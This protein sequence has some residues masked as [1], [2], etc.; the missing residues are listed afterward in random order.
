MRIKIAVF[1]F[2]FFCFFALSGAAQTTIDDE[3]FQS[4]NDIQ[5]TVPMTKKVDLYTAFTARLGKNISRINDSRFAVGFIFKPTKSL[6][7]QPFYWRIDARNANSRF[8][9]EHRLNFRVNYRFPFKKFG[10]SHRSGFEYRLRRPRNS[11]RYRPSLTFEKAIPKTFIAKANFFV[12]EEIF[13]DSLLKRFSRNRFTVGINKTLNK[14]L[15]LD[16]YFMRQNDGTT[17]PGDFNVVGTALK[18]KF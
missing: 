2:L 15:S 6:S 3:D 17:R 1:G 18:V 16:I 13:Y 8:R 11:F 4:W 10:L 12:T 9:P 5:L 14:N 7:F